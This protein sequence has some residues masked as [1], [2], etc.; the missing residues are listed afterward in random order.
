MKFA[1]CTLLFFLFLICPNNATAQTANEILDRYFAAIGGLEKFD[2]I[3]T[4]TAE[5]RREVDGTAETI[6]IT[7]EGDGLWREEVISNGG[8]HFT[9]LTK[10]GGWEYNEYGG[11]KLKKLKKSRKDKYDTAANIEPSLTNYKQPGFLA[12]LLG[13][14]SAD[15]KQCFKLKINEPGRQEIFVW[16]D[17]ES[18]LKIQSAVPTIAGVYNRQNKIDEVQVNVFT[19]FRNYKNVDGLLFPFT[20]LINALDILSNEPVRKV[21]TYFNKIAINKPVDPRLYKPE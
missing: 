20:C 5:G 10:E 6:T 16:F 9:L 8:R 4:E 3:T 14:D 21:A 1:C 12:M 7:K 15:G 11:K 19:V 13:K 2:S 17:T 18:F